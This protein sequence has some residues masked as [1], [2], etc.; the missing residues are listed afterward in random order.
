MAP[1]TPD[2]SLDELLARVGAGDPEAWQWLVETYSGRVYGLLL[3]QCGDRELAEEMTQET[4]VR[5]VTHIDRY[6]EEGRFEPWLFRIAMNRL[7]DEMRR[8]RRQARPV[9]MSAGRAADAEN[10]SDSPWQ[11]M[12]EKVVGRELM[13]AP[14]PFDQ[15][16]RNEQ[17]ERIREAVEQLSH[18]DREILYL[19]HT[20]GMRFNEIAEM[21]QEPLGTVLARGHR[22]LCKLRKM[23][24]LDDDKTTGNHSTQG[25]R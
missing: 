2:N 22:A 12:Q 14:C 15:A 24:E 6:H 20:A 11:A 21:L 18:A 7:R 4:F 19:R 8:R 10:A 25:G 3:K 5:V 13:V 17:I 9:D 1:E 23:L 16:S